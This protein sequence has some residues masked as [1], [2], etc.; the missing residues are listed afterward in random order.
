MKVCLLC[1][2]N[3][4]P[5]LNLLDLL[6]F[7]KLTLSVIC[8]HCLDKFELLGKNRCPIC[9]KTLASEGICQD[10]HNWQKIY[11]NQLLKNHAK[12]KYNQAFHD[13]MVSY[14]RYGDYRLKSVL[15]VLIKN[16]LNKLEFDCYVPIPSSPEHFQKRQYDTIYEIYQD[17]KPL[18]QLLK[19]E[20]G[21]KAQG[22][23]NKLERLQSP[24]KFILDKEKIIIHPKSILLLDDIYTTGRT[25][26]HARDCLRQA[27][28]NARIESFTICH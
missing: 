23:K 1:G 2:Q 16:E 26:Y 10:C 14:K 22:E 17:L 18:T 5:D 15:Q 21:S 24:Q 4:V 3:F 8:R 28:S 27:F 25:L 13:L 9:D 20:A 12:Y 19:K 7:K 11:P 6:N